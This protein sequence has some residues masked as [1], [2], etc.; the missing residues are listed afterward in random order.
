MGPL[1][2]ELSLTVALTFDPIGG[3][4]WVSDATTGD[5]LSCNVTDNVPCTIEVVASDITTGPLGEFG[6]NLPRGCVPNF[7]SHLGRWPCE[8][9]GHALYLIES[10]RCLSLHPSFPPSLLP[11]LPPLPS[12]L[13]PSPLPPSPLPPPPSSLPPSLPSP[14][15][16]PFLL[17]PALPATSIALD[18]MSIY[19]S[20]DGSEVFY[21]A[22]DKSN[23][24]V[25]A[26]GG[27]NVSTIVTLSPG[28]QPL[29][30]E[31]PL[32]HHD[33]A[34]ADLQAA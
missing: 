23:V 26:E 16:P 5:I 3:R 27:D 12:P 28:L 9:D 7:S 1:L 17:P 34:T 2:S 24:A 20:L 4:L 32:H 13:P 25:M 6:K 10:L 8:L 11:P 18:E 30:S 19:W 22:R 15:F 29:P 33:C 31:P 21:V 14:L